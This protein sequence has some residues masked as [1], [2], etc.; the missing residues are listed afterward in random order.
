M[1]TT[2]K[3]LSVPFLSLLCTRK[4][5]NVNMNSSVLKASMHIVCREK[6]TLAE[7]VLQKSLEMQQAKA[8]AGVSPEASNASEQVLLHSNVHSM[9]DVLYHGSIYALYSL[10]SVSWKPDVRGAQ[11]LS[12]AEAR[13]LIC[14]MWSKTSFCC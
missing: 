12:I 4:R 8:A 5:F 3:L 6:A 1:K 2:Q 13:L 11:Q 10:S 7:Q 9:Q 14:I